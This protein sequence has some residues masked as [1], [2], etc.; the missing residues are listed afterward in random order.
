MIKCL[1]CGE[2]LPD[3]QRLSTHI[4]NHG[5]T[6]EEYYRKYLTHNKYEGKCKICG[7]DVHRVTLKN[8]FAV[9]CSIECAKKDSKYIKSLFVPFSEKAITCED[10]KQKIGN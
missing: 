10:L 4:K 5:L 3:I 2:H 8:G 7:E 9:Y 6:V 1:E